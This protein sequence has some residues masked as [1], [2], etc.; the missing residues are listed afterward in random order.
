MSALDGSSVA[1]AR[2]VRNVV[3][4]LNRG[5]EEMARRRGAGDGSERQQRRRGEGVTIRKDPEIIEDMLRKRR[6]K[7]GVEGTPNKGIMRTPTG[8]SNKNLMASMGKGGRG[9]GGLGTPNSE[10]VR[11]LWS[12][13]RN[14]GRG[15]EGGKAF[16]SRHNSLMPR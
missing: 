6:R 10:L 16:S 7:G 2:D 15:E 4:E 9:V 8:A 5:R 11:D 12:R 1:Y 13:S 14:L 3:D